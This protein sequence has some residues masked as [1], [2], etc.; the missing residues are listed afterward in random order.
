MEFICIARCFN[1]NRLWE[2]GQK[3]SS[4][5]DLSKPSKEG[6]IVSWE[7]IGKKVVEV[8]NSDKK[9]QTD[10][11]KMKVPLLVLYAK[12]R[13][14]ADIEGTRPELLKKIGLLEKSRKKKNKLERKP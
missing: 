6:E 8:L 9:P 5:S 2:I 14:D 7:K 1:E 10:I 11:F 12:K 3:R 13:F 4:K